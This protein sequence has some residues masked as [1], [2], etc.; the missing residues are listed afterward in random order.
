MGRSEPVASNSTVD[1]NT[2]LK[3]PD[4]FAFEDNRYVR[5]LKV[6]NTVADPG[7]GNDST[8]QLDP[9]FINSD[10]TFYGRVGES[11]LIKGTNVNA[12]I[13]TITG[14]A[15][16]IFIT[17]KPHRSTDTIGQ[18]DAG[19]LLPIMNGGKAAGTGQITSAF[20][21]FTRR[22]FYLQIFDETFG[23]EGSQLTTQEYFDVFEKDGKQIPFAMGLYGESQAQ[24]RLNQKMSGAFLFGQENT[25]TSMT[26][27]TPR[28]AT[29]PVGYTKGFFPTIDTNGEIFSIAPN[30][31]TIDDFNNVGL[32]M[33][34]QQTSSKVVM[35]AMGAKRRNE[36]DTLVKTYLNNNGTDYSAPVKS[37]LQGNSTDGRAALLE[38][39]EIATGGYYYLLKTIEELSDPMT[40]GITGYDLDWTGFFITLSSMKDP[41]TGAKLDN[42]ATRYVEYN[43]YNR[44]YEMW[45]IGAAGGDTQNYTSDVDERVYNIRS[46]KGLQLLKMNQAIHLT[47]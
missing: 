11:I 22:N 7:A 15:P 1:P 10:G 9:S 27:T 46:H 25:N 8:F 14:T 20:S 31:M 16:N 12:R 42:I 47:K 19:Q 6:Y 26:Q 32:Y 43:G 5:P 3:Q 39:N 17:L 18:L 30:T 33:L 13:Q 23:L 38:F 28:G 37:M 45:R 29:N 40:Y 36:I 2:G 34:S 4:W 41:V 21:G 44:N 24:Y 35:A